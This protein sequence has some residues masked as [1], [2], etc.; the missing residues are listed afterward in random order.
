MW[1]IQFLITWKKLN[2]NLIC[3]MI[4]VFCCVLIFP[5]VFPAEIE[6]F[7][8]AKQLTMN[9]RHFFFGFKINFPLFYWSINK[10]AAVYVSFVVIFFLS[11]WLKP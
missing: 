4:S 8:K 3:Q 10:T 7:L 5:Q 2:E 1:K 11:C 6:N 9:L